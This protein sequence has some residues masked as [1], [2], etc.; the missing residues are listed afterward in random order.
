MIK[1]NLG[2]IR[3]RK[4]VLEPPTTTTTKLKY[5]SDPAPLAG[6]KN[7]IR[8]CM[9]FSQRR[10]LYLTPP[11]PPA[12]KIY[13]VKT[14]G[15]WVYYNTSIQ[16][17]VWMSMNYMY[18]HM[19]GFFLSLSKRALVSHMM[20]S[21]LVLRGIISRSPLWFCGKRTRN[22]P[23]RISRFRFPTKTKSKSVLYVLKKTMRLVT[24]GSNLPVY[25]G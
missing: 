10:Y 19:P 5:P 6:E 1:M 15:T 8:A 12:L 9:Q 11:P 3:Y 22:F 14:T 17:Q 13:H 18:L 7:W 24:F 25:Y 2:T 16:H 4:C 20:Y 21:V 23:W